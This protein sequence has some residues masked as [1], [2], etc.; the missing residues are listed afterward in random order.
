MRAVRAIELTGDICRKDGSGLGSRATAR[1]VF[2]ISLNRLG[3]RAANCVDSIHTSQVQ[4]PPPA[5]R[6]QEEVET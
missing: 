6:G 5:R 4:A 3:L 2:R 1:E